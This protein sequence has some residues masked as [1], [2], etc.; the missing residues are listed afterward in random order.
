MSECENQIVD[1]RVLAV[2]FVR[3]SQTNGKAFW[4]KMEVKHDS[5]GVY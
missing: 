5:Y 4:Q 1:C 2:P 3:G